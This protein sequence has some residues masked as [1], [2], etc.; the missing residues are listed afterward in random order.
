[1]FRKSNPSFSRA[2]FQESPHKFYARHY[3]QTLPY[4]KRVENYKRLSQE[5]KEEIW[6]EFDRACEKYL[7][8]FNE[9]FELDF[10]WKVEK[11]RLSRYG[12]KRYEF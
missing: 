7:R 9:E 1:M 10:E 6:A 5:E 2:L 3:D 4:K 11:G 8:Q 12:S